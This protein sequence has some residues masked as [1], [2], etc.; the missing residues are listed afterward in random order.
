MAYGTPSLYTATALQN[1]QVRN[2]KS[3]GAT[4][5]SRSRAVSNADG[6]SFYSG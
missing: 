2:D 3:A 6:S 4:R 5:P 1:W